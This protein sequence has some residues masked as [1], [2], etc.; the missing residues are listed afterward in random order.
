MLSALLRQAFNGE[1][2]EFRVLV[3]NLTGLLELG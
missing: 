3:T 2:A 1:G